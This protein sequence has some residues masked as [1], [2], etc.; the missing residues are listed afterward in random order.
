[1][2]VSQAFVDPHSGIE[3]GL[4]AQVTVEQFTGPH[5]AGTTGLH[6]HTLEPVSRHK[7]V[8]SIGYQDVASIGRLFATGRVDTRRIIS[9]AGPPVSDPRLI[10]TRCGAFIDDLV[11]ENSISE[12]FAGDELRYVSGSVLSGKKAMGESFGFMGRFDQQ[13][14]ILKEG[15]ERFFMGWLTPGIDAFSS[16]PIYLSKFFPKMKFAMTTST[17]G[18]PRAMVPIGMYERVMPMDILPTFL[19]RSMM[20]GDLEKAEQLGALEL[21]EEDL[22]LCTFVCPGKTNYGPILRR[23]LELIEKEG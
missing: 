6:I 21:D 22:A 16:I 15:R 4:S 18:S 12:E 10:E 7:T 13:I 1:M 23:N 11:D 19:L 8:W 20:V 14:S 17:H 3:K 2:Q 9:L 5:P